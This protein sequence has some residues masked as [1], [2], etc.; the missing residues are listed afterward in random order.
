MA[1]SPTI[2]SQTAA[3]TMPK[4]CEATRCGGPAA[5]SCAVHAA[6]QDTP[7]LARTVLGRLRRTN[8]LFKLSS[9]P[10]PLRSWGACAMHAARPDPQATPCRPHRA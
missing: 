9:H 7:P 8:D 1:I 6:H 5:G 2:Q 10:L 4:V 3:C